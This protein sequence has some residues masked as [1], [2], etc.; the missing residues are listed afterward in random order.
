MSKSKHGVNDLVLLEDLSNDAIF[1]CLE[2]H[3]KGDEIY[4]YIGQVL[5]SVNPFKNIGGLYSSGTLGKY[6]GKNAHQNQPHVY[7]IAERAYR[8]MVQDLSKECVI[9]SGESGAG[10][11]EASKKIMEYIAAVSSKAKEVQKVKEQLLESNPFL[12]AF[13]NAKTVRNN[14]SSRFGKYME[15]QFDVADPV[16]GRISV[17]LLEKNRVIERQSSERSFHIFYQLLKGAS[18]EEKKELSLGDTK[19]Y[20]Y[21]SKSGCDQVPGINDKTEWRETRQAMDVIGLPK[22]AQTQIFQLLSGVLRLGNMT[23]KSTGSRRDSCTS[24][25][26]EDA[27]IAGAMLGLEAGRLLKEICTMRIRSGT[28][29][30]DKPLEADK[31]AHARD[32]LAKGIYGRLFE[33]LVKQANS[34]IFVDF[35][36]NTIGVLDIYG[37]EIFGENGFEQLCINY[38]NEKLHQ[39]FIELTLK[40]EQD[41]YK[42]EGIEWEAV[43]YYN[44]LPICE[45]IEKRGNIFSL[46]DEESIFPKGTDESMYDKLKNQLSR[47]NNFKVVLGKVGGSKKTFEIKHYAGDVTYGITGFLDK[48]KDLLYLNLVQMAGESKNS[49]LRE[50]FAADVEASRNSRSRPKTSCMQFKKQVAELMST[51]KSCRQHYIRCIKPNEAK[52]PQMVEAEMMMAQI[53][54]LGLLENVKVRRAGYAYR[55]PFGELLAKYKACSSRHIDFTEDPKKASTELLSQLG[56]KDFKMGKTKVFI[57]SPT[58]LFKLEDMRTEFLA[59]AAQKLPPEDQMVYADKVKGFTGP[60]VKGDLLLIIAAQACYIWGKDKKKPE[61]VIKMSELQ[62]LSLPQDL[63]GHCILHCMED[64]T[65][66]KVKEDYEPNVWD[67]LIE[68][69][70]KRE[71]LAVCEVL[72]TSGIKLDVRFSDHIPEACDPA[73]QKQL[74][75]QKKR[76]KCSI[77]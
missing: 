30:L 46:L 29:T 55:I 37:F 48:N 65:G 28:E 42:A 75:T 36:S 16:G 8:K 9:I 59:K 73:F 20:L 15:I 49:L 34:S 77:M 10:K 12:E 71:L 3:Y 25:D 23:F 31:A 57:R 60:G 24:L 22:E 76:S 70:Y 5:I 39:L 40:A 62:G 50:L 61:Q 32:S 72:G 21:L 68:N 1:K 35:F 19:D 13:G 33:W 51:L 64:L 7:A 26:K 45:L 66:K 27:E 2:K 38:V 14:N 41:E 17:Y 47:N 58:T 69:V 44:N 74:R 56:I 52:R 43:K 53:K 18:S 11:T 54:Y 4:S 6:K 63:E 67:V